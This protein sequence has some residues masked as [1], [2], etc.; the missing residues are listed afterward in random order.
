MGD[1]HQGTAPLP[2]AP[3]SFMAR[4]VKRHAFSVLPI[5]MRHALHVYHL[6]EYHSDP[7]DRLLVAQAT[8]ETLTVVTNDAAIK[9]YDVDIVW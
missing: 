8:L 2:E 5:A 1:R 3:D 4:M 7:F 9:R 6:P